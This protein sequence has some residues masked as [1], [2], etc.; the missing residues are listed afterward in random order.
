MI[1][2][3]RV[4]VTYRIGRQIE[5]LNA[6]GMFPVNPLTMVLTSFRKTNSTGL[7]KER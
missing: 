6:I 2:K 7:I 3:E 4:F 1:L 5:N